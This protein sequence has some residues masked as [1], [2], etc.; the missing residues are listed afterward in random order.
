[1]PTEQELLDDIERVHGRLGSPPSETDYREHGEYSPSAVRSAF[2]KFTNGREE[3]DIPNPD[4]R[5]GHN[6]IA[7]EDLIDAIHTLAEDVGGTP[8]RDQMNELGEYAEKPY[9]REFGGW[10]EALF[11]AGYEYDD[12]NRAGSHVAE[13]VNVECSGPDCERIEER[14][15]SRIKTQKNVF[16]SRGCLNDWKSVNYPETHNPPTFTGEAHPRWVEKTELVEDY[17]SVASELKKTPSQMEYNE[18]GDYSWMAIRKHFDGMGDLQKTAGVERLRKGRVTLN[19]EIC[20]SQ[21]SVKHSKKDSWRFCSRE[22]TA[23]WMIEEYSGE[24]NPNYVHGKEF[25]T[26]PNWP[27]QSTR[28]KER[29]DYICQRCGEDLIDEQKRANAH[30]MIPYV[31]FDDYR[32]AN[33]LVNLLTLCNSCHGYVEFGSESVQAKIEMFNLSQRMP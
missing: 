1:M 2:G 20:G 24:G 19:C 6:R 31:D 9:R 21:K 14:L 27:Q 22:C 11:A 18:H 29:D 10:S 13:R 15:K 28:A 3:A 17:Q 16:C 7:R 23:E 5:G 12:L 30:H 26:G 33:Q 25:D 4:M 8:T 32:V